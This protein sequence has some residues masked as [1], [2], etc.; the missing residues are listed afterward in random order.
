MNAKNNTRFLSFSRL[1][2]TFPF[3]G[4]GV[5]WVEKEMNY[6]LKLGNESN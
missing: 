2:R 1:W 3:F 6:T 4:G 5:G